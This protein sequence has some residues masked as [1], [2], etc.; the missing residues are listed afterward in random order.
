[1]RRRLRHG[2]ELVEQHTRHPFR[3]GTVLGKP[4][5]PGVRARFQM[6]QAHRQQVIG[7]LNFTV[8][9]IRRAHWQDMLARDLQ[10]VDTM[11]VADVVV[12]RRIQLAPLEVKGRECGQE[13]HGNFRMRESEAL[14]TR[15]EPVKT[16]GR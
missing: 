1:V 13:V 11:P 15:S 2:R 12:K 5:R 9:E 3:Y 10:V 7:R 6:Q 14:E 4:V 16:E 8:Q